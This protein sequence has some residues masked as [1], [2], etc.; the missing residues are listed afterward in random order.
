MSKELLEKL[1]HG[2]YLAGNYLG[3]VGVA[4]VFSSGYDLKL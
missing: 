2:M 3:K 4:D 1:P